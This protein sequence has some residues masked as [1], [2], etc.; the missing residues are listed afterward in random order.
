[1]TLKNVEM[2]EAIQTYRLRKKTL[3][4]LNEER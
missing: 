2:R 3:V 1:M 4:Q